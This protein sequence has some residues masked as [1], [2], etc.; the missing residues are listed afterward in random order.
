VL[1]VLAYEESWDS[2]R[3]DKPRGVLGAV[4]ALLGLFAVM[5]ALWLVLE[6]TGDWEGE[7]KHDHEGKAV[8]DAVPTVSVKD[9]KDVGKKEI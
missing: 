2:W 1:G 4:V 6:G 7:K 3:F 5:P 9:K 8:V